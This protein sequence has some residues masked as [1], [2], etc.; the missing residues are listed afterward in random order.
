M[1][2][3]SNLELQISSYR[4]DMAFHWAN[5]N[6]FTNEHLLNMVKRKM[7]FQALNSYAYDSFETC[8]TEYH[9][10]GT[11]EIQVMH[12]HFYA[13]NMHFSWQISGNIAYGTQFWFTIIRCNFHILRICC[14]PFHSISMR[15]RE[16]E[17]VKLRR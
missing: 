8:G 6:E 4:C 2:W 5:F 14:I 15:E 1:S 10:V 16:R 17:R 3:I 7:V 9:F 12:F 11:N 13:Y